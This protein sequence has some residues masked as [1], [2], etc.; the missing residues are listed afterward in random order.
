M[1]HHKGF[2]PG[3]PGVLTD[4]CLEHLLV[5]AQGGFDFPRFDTL[6]VDLDLL[7]MTSRQHNFA[8]GQPVAQ[9]AAAEVTARTG[10]IRIEQDKALVLRATLAQI[11]QGQRLSRHQ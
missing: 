9:V 8:I 3:L 2:K 7:V 6:P 5:T 1:Y 4:Q 11:P 10:A